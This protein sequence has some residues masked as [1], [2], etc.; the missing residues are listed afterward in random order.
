M[1]GV[2]DD[3]N[4]AAEQTGDVIGSARAAEHAMEQLCRATI[5]QPSMTSAEIDVVLAHLAATAAALPQSVRQLGDIL[6]LARKYHSLEMDGLTES[7]DPDLA[8][9]TA[10]FHLE[11]VRELA[12][13]LHRVLDA[14]HN[15]T[16][17]IAVTVRRAHRPGEDVPSATSPVSRPDE[18]QPPSMGCGGAG[19]SLQR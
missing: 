14:A 5:G 16:A 15:E 7:E 12:L 18:R 19:T 17:H 11:A 3:D 13:S 9:D 2:H 6:A 8:I 10:Q 1:R 4:T